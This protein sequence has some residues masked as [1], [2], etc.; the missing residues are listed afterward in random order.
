MN[1][2]CPGRGNPTREQNPAYGLLQPIIFI[3][4][5]SLILQKMDD[6]QTWQ[7]ATTAANQ[8]YS[9][10]TPE[11]I[12]ELDKLFQRI[13]RMK[14]ELLKVPLSSGSDAVCLTCKGLCCMH[15]KYY[16]T[17]IDLLAFRFLNSETVTPEFASTPDCPYGSSTGCKMP[18]RFRPL[19]CVIFNC[20]SID[21]LL[22][23]SQRELDR[24]TEQQ[25]R[26]T[27][28]EVEGIIGFPLGRPALLFVN[29]PHMIARK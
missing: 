25:L 10:L 13:V 17:M 8:I 11:Q 27:I 28:A 4:K 9:L 23:D 3:G 12:G 24:L 6:N 7:K 16:L 2:H 19:T 18:P 22:T 14:E 5:R 1:G 26:N 29:S 20:E 15:G 21:A